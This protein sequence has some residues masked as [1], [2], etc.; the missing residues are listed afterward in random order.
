MIKEKKQETKDPVVQEQQPP[1]P[2]KENDSKTGKEDGKQK[3]S[4]ALD[5]ME[6]ATFDAVSVKKSTP[7]CVEMIV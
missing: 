5:D 7:C 1:S 4:Y 2:Q 3:S 6:K